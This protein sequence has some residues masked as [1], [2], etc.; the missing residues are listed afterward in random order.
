MVMELTARHPMAWLDPLW[1]RFHGL[2]REPP[3]TA[4]DAVAVLEELG[5]TPT[6]VRWA[7]PA[8]LPEDPEWVARRLCLPPEPG[9]DGRADR[10]RP[11]P[12]S[13]GGPAD[14][15]LSAS[16]GRRPLGL[17]NAQLTHGF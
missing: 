7:R 10:G 17:T 3:A 15:T 13:T 5:I 12:A 14:P 2:H 9:Q 1:V 6:V 11:G 16:V 8:R 4:D